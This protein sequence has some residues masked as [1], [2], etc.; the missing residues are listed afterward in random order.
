MTVMFSAT[1]SMALTWA[2]GSSIM[3]L[4][5]LA[6]Q[7]DLFTQGRDMHRM[8]LPLNSSN[9]NKRPVYIMWTPISLTTKHA[10]VKHFVALMKKVN[11]FIHYI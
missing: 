1:D 8:V 10:N 4:K 9:D 11:N 2:C 5:F 6:D 7:S 3:Q